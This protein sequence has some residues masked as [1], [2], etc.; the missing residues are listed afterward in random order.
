[1]RYLSFLLVTLIISLPGLKGIAQKKLQLLPPSFDAYISNVLKT[2]EVPG[3]SVAI[4]KDGKVILAKGYGV[5]RMD[6]TAPINE[7]TLFLIASNS[8]AFTATSLAI[9]VEEGKLRWEDKVVQ[10]LPWF[11]M[12]DDYVTNHLTVRDLLVHHSGLSAYAGD[13]MLFPPS[14]Y[15]RREIL[16]KLQFLPLKYD[17]RTRIFNAVLPFAVR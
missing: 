10:Y 14:S 2:F 11:K 1:M 16:D 3:V 15:S 8:K 6:E 4:V 9:L 17:F 5:K 12:S 13:V 7:N